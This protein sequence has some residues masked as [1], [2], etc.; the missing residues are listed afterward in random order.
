[1]LRLPSVYKTFL[2]TSGGARISILGIDIN[3]KAS[4]AASALVV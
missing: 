1:M 2:M 4:C 3:R